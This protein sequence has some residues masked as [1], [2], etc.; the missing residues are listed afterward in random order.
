MV[1]YNIALDL[2]FHSVLRK[3][4]CA[5]KYNVWPAISKSFYKTMNNGEQA[6]Q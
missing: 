3:K 4:W 2:V 5:F 1:D 6:I